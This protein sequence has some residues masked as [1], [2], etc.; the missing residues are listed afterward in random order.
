MFRRDIDTSG[1][2]FEDGY[3]VLLYGG[4]ITFAAYIYY[5]SAPRIIYHAITVQKFQVAV[6]MEERCI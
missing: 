5:D 1:R 3:D 6:K 2:S 4:L